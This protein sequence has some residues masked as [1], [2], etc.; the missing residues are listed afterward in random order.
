MKYYE[1]AC[2]REIGQGC[3]LAQEISLFA[4]NYTKDKWKYLLTRGCKLDHAGSCYQLA[5]YAQNYDD[6]ATARWGFQ[7]ACT[8]DILEACED[9]RI[10]NE[11]GI[12]E[13]WW[14]KHRIE[15]INFRERI[16]FQ[17]ENLFPAGPSRP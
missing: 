17:L 7:R 8:M 10:L 2:D 15:F 13:K 11:G 3:F 5:L 1:M 4:Q 16:L 6:K 9:F 12:I 14:Q